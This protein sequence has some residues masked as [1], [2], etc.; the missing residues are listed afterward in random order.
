MAALPPKTPPSVLPTLK[1]TSQSI[2]IPGLP[3]IAV[4]TMGKITVAV[5]VIVFILLLIF[6][7][8]FL[9]YTISFPHVYKN[10]HRKAFA[11][12]SV[13]AAGNLTLE[14][15]FDTY[16]ILTNSTFAGSNPN[17]AA[18][19]GSVT[20]TLNNSNYDFTTSTVNAYITSIENPGLISISKTSQ[21]LTLKPYKLEDF[22]SFTGI[23][24]YTFDLH[25]EMQQPAT[26]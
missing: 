12:V 17:V 18:A 24:P 6:L 25:V 19:D 8:M 5:S 21:V 9:A 22:S 26:M 11:T 23:L 20:V 4:P 15:V 13:D 16:K 7:V 14:N 3:A 1:N 10:V 2:A